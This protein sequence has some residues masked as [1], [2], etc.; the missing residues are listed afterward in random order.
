[1]S[2]ENLQCMD[3][4]KQQLGA[5]SSNTDPSFQTGGLSSSNLPSTRYPQEPKSPS[6]TLLDTVRPAKYC[7]G[8]GLD[9]YY[10]SE[11]I[12]KGAKTN[13]ISQPAPSMLHGNLPS[14]DRTS[15]SGV[16]HGRAQPGQLS[17][18]YGP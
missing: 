14:P 5:I 10:N 18:F 9:Y 6:K 8:C 1:M 12:N 4:A 13:T 2:E 17:E 3:K 11:I 16:T 7:A 15:F